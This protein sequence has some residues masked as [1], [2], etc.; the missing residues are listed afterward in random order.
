MTS[1]PTPHHQQF[2]FSAWHGTPKAMT[3]PHVHTDIE[4]N[5]FLGGDGTYFM[6]GRVY[7]VPPHRLAVFWAGMPHRLIQV[8]TG[9]EYLCMTLP[10]AWFLSWRIESGLT[11]RL[12]EGELALEP[13]EKQS[14]MDRF[15]FQRWTEDLTIGQ[16]EAHRIAALEVEARLR[17]LALVQPMEGEGAT[18][19]TRWEMRGDRTALSPAVAAMTEFVGHHYQEP[20]TVAGIAA[21]ANLN[22][23][24]AMTAFKEGCGVPLWEYV[25]RLRISHAQRFLL[26][27]DWTVERIA[28]ECGFISSGRFYAAFR[29]LCGTTPREY[30]RR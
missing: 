1:R 28:G 9:A 15:L 27:T 16:G 19:E 24:Y 6:A 17:R 18:S 22:P 20:I 30:R 10:L 3:G 5:Y 25:L 7:R 12:L 8:G 2:P 23:N 29:R 13:D 4:L 14:V 26:T 21:A 11:Q